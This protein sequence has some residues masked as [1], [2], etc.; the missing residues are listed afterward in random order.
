MLAP[1]AMHFLVHSAAPALAP[2]APHLESLTQP[3]TVFALPMSS[4]ETTATTINRSDNARQISRNFFIAEL[5][6]S[7]ARRP[8]ICKATSPGAP[9][10]TQGYLD[11]RK[12]SAMVTGL[13]PISGKYNTWESAG[14][15]TGGIERGLLA[16][17]RRGFDVHNLA[18]ASIVKL[19]AGLFF[20]GVGIGLQ[21]FDLGG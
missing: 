11:R 14:L 9:L 20:D 2:F 19:F 12:K 21:G 5:L 10:Q 6:D 8:G 7:A 16:R 1:S 3:L 4:A 17:R 13:W 18:R 15:L